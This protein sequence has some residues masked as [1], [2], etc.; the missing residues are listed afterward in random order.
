MTES[1][2]IGLFTP[3]GQEVPVKVPGVRFTC[4]V[5]LPTAWTFDVSNGLRREMTAAQETT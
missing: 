4:S 5:F 2:R 1:W 3:V